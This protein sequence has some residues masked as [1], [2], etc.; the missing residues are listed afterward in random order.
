MLRRHGGWWP[1]G[2]G[3]GGRRGRRCPALR[4][5]GR[6]GRG[7]GRGRW[8]RGGVGP[9]RRGARRAG[10]RGFL[11]GLQTVPQE[12]VALVHGL[13][14]CRA[15]GRRAVLR[16]KRHGPACDAGRDQ[17]RS[18]IS[19]R[20]RRGNPQTRPGSL[21]DRR[22]AAIAALSTSIPG[23]G[24]V[25]TGTAKRQQQTYRGPSIEAASAR[26]KAGGGGNHRPAPRHRTSADQRQPR[27]LRGCPPT[28]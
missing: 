20:G 2:R 17:Y 8:P 21:R 16:D 7:G 9:V 22:A 5:S 12:F 25:T 28:V 13:L 1:E 14:R 6:P 23:V 10:R 24:A 27:N 26:W 15:V 4:R 11:R 18:S 3:G 19:S